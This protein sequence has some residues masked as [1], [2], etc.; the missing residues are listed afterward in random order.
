MKLLVALIKVFPPSSRSHLRQIDVGPKEA[1][2]FV[3][4]SPHPHFQLKTKV[5]LS[6]PSHNFAFKINSSWVYI[7][8]CHIHIMPLSNFINERQRT[9]L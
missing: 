9:N 4:V 3:T 1:N 5:E 7:L 6:P 2:V 8:N